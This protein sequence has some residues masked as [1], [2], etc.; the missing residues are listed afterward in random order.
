[1]TKK[2]KEVI[3]EVTQRELRIANIYK[4]DKKPTSKRMY[5]NS[6]SAYFALKCL[7]TKLKIND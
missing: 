4:R 6:L 3:R 7:M 5:E 1:M 2:E